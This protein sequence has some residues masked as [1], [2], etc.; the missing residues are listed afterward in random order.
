VGVAFLVALGLAALIIGL[1]M[2]R[3]SE[4]I[5]STTSTTGASTRVVIPQ[6]ASALR[7]AEILQEQGVVS[8]AA[9]FLDAVD[10]QGASTR[11]QPG[12]YELAAGQ[13]YPSIID[14]LTKGDVSP[15]LKLTI[16][17]G[18]AIEQTALRLKEQ[19]RLNGDEY[20]TLAR[21]PLDFTVP[22]VGGSV[23]QV[24]SLEGLLFPSTYALG[25][26]YGPAE[27]IAEQLTAFAD[28]TSGLPWSRAKELGITPYQAVIVASMVEKEASV[29]DERA[30]V[31]AVIYNRLAKKMPLQIDATTRYALKKW[32]GPLTESDLAT[33]SPYNTR[34]KPG[35]PPGPIASPG[36][37]ALEAAL[38]PASV[39]YLYYVL[40]DK[41]G[42][43]F[44]TASYQEFLKAKER[45]PAP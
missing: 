2:R 36:V 18:L 15:E 23:P 44:F 21:R 37:A 35:L 42:H 6:G 39:D 33:S 20:A 32:T 31:A 13:D 34:S 41:E 11:L 14:K 40:V 29:P 9:G 19:G 22:P 4:P 5:V 25:E 45:A 3:H 7:V 17:E 43:H 28:H 16:P 1:N 24:T 27:L 10:A 12:T 30:K 38:T 8:S 26:T